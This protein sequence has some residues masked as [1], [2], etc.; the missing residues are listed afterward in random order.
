M[1]MTDVL[2]RLRRRLGVAALAFSALALVSCGGGGASLDAP[3]TVDDVTG[4]GRLMGATPLPDVAAAQVAAAL[5][6]AGDKAPPFAPHYDVATWRIE[7]LTLDADGLE[8]R[9]SGLLALPRKPPGA[10]SPV[11]SYQHGTIFHDAEA[12]SNAILPDEP[13]IVMASLGYIVLA[14]DYVGYGSS[15][16]SDHPY[17]L[18]APSASTVIDLL[19]AGRTWRLRNGVVANG[20]LFLAG[21]SEGGYT[22]MAAHRALEAGSSVHRPELVSVVPGAGPYDVA[23]TLDALLQRVKDENAFLGAFI[24]PGFLRYMPGAIRV[25]VRRALVRKLVPDDADVKFDSRFVDAFFED[26]RDKIER[27]SNVH[28]WK[29][30]RRTRLFHGRGDQTVPYISATNTL[31]AMLARGAPD[32]T[33]TDCDATPSGH[34]Q[35]VPPYCAFMAAELAERARDL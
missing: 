16:S 14:A 20:Q 8:V 4:P 10:R 13:P 35:C 25:E 18:S 29:P 3:T 31:Q 34:L 2:G 30:E 26:D 11:L 19:S 9:A 27:Q 12:P 15:R 22:T 21:Y 1:G 17:L 6:A 24:D 5:A 32:V 7:Y 28:N 33:L 23:A